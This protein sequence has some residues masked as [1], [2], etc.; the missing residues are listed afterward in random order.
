MYGCG[1][2]SLVYLVYLCID[3]ADC[4]R[5]FPLFSGEDVG[6]WAAAGKNGT[7]CLCLVTRPLT[8]LA[9]A[10]VS[11][12]RSPV[13]CRM[14][15]H[16]SASPCTT[17]PPAFPFPLLTHRISVRLPCADELVVLC[18]IAGGRRR[19]AGQADVGKDLLDMEERVGEAGRTA[20]ECYGIHDVNDTCI[21]HACGSR[22]IVGRPSRR[23][24]LRHRGAQTGFAQ[25]SV[26]GQRRNS[27]SGLR[28]GSDQEPG[29][30]T[31]ASVH[32]AREA[33][34][35]KHLSSVDPSTSSSC[36]NSSRPRMPDF[37]LPAR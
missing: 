20:Q 29:A 28:Q 23:P 36:T 16:R 9:P 11:R 21:V 8:Q 33:E 5:Y 22:C 7:F 17:K 24:V 18:L 3:K 37:G 13:P 25:S 32:G 27:Q 19:G 35:A 10:N 30:Q 34:A 26:T 31:R 14:T 1:G 15:P 4:P 2:T 6:D 12:W